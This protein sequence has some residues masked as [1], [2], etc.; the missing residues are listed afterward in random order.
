MVDRRTRPALIALALVVGCSS[1]PKR[2]LPPPPATE[3]APIELVETQPAETTLDSELPDAHVVWLELI[4]TARTSIDFAEFYAANAPNSRL[5]PIVKAIEDAVARG[6]RVRFLA[7]VTF[8]REYADTLDR[9]QRAGA[10]VR[11]L[12]LSGPTGG[13][14]HAK[15]FVVD[16]REAYLGSQ[17]FDWRSLEHIEEL[18]ARLRDRQLV[19]DLATIFTND[20]ARAGNEPAP[21]TVELGW[22]IT[23]RVK[24]ASVPP[25]PAIAF[26]ASPKELLPAGIRWDL[27][28]LV[29]LIASA[30]HTV[31]VQLMTYRAGDWTELEQPLLD[32]AKRGVRVELLLA[33][34][35]KRDK[36]IGGLQALARTPNLEIRFVTIPE[37]SSGFIPFARVVHAKLLVVDRAR[38]WVGTSNWERE[39]FYQS[40]NV[41]LII[42]HQ[43]LAERIA[44]WSDAT[45]TSSYATRVDPDAKYTAPRIK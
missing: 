26:V 32:A 23:G 19:S 35:S 40:R 16:G 38:A 11:T 44:A 4:Q 8:V 39:Y 36:T 25:P 1:A 18:G 27:P 7:E 30:R 42:D 14:L 43:P 37:H 41:G 15:Y 34:W 9:L 22:Q 20:W 33:D 3:P 12:D 31:R 45:W 5:E 21:K 13:I 6:V 28:E 10:Q 29:A 2:D 17:N 24:H